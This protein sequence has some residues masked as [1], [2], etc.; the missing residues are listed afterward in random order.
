MKLHHFFQII[1]LSLSIALLS[2]ACKKEDTTPNIDGQWVSAS[3]ENLGNG[4]WG[5]REFTFTKDTWDLSFTYY[6]DSLRTSKV[7]T[8]KVGGKRTVLGE[9]E[10]FPGAEKADFYAD[11]KTLTL[12]NG[13]VAEAF[14]FQNCGLVVGQP[15]DIS[16]GCSFFDNSATCPKEHDII[17]FEGNTLFLGDRSK[18]LCEEANRPTVKGNPLVKR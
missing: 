7:F 13:S 6:F 18:S 5:Y 10:S 12:W 15:V 9:F 16:G 14:G 11:N 17:L 3:T 2:M 4:G 1:F 8:L